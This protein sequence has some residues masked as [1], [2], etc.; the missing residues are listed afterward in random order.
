MC[1]Q[2]VALFAPVRMRLQVSLSLHG[3]TL[4]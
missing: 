2:S 3:L 4:N 1:D